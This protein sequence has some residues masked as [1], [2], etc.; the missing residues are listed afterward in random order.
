MN[1]KAHPLHDP[2]RNSEDCLLI[3]RKN[4]LNVLKW[5]MM[6]F[7][8]KNFRFIGY[9]NHYTSRPHMLTNHWYKGRKANSKHPVHASKNFYI[10]F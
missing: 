2:S 1:K 4:I 6:S 9:S 10:H 5:K 8:V 3:E 7:S